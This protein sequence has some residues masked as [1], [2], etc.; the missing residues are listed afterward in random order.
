MQRCCRFENAWKAAADVYFDE[1]GMG[2][3]KGKATVV[4]LLLYEAARQKENKALGKRS[5]LCR[6]QQS[7]KRQVYI[8]LSCMGHP[9]V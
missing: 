8:R 4:L 2:G 3:V 7:R 9:A 6:W 5:G 1:M